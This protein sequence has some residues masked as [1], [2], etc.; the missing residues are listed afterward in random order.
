MNSRTSAIHCV[1][2]IHYVQ[3]CVQYMHCV[4]YIHC[5]LSTDAKTLPINPAFCGF[6]F[7]IYGSS[8]TTSILEI[9]HKS[10]SHATPMLF[11]S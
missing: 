8:W 10:S 7:Q 4:Q 11:C 6:Q 5:V 1:Q 3:Y 9:S 2:Y